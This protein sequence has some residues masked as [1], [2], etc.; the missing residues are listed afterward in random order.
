MGSNNYVTPPASTNAQGTVAVSVAPAVTASPVALGANDPRVLPT[1]SAAAGNIKLPYDTNSAYVE[2]VASAT[3]YAVPQ[4]NAGATGVAFGPVT[5]VNLDSSVIVAAG[6]NP[7]TGDQSHGWHNITSVGAI[8]ATTVNATNISA[9]GITGTTVAAD[10]VQAKTTDGNLT[11]Q[12]NGAG[13]AVAVASGKTLR[14]GSNAGAPSGIAVG[15]FY[16]DSTAK[17]PAMKTDVG[18]VD[19]P[20]TVYANTG[21]S[22]TINGVTLTEF[23]LTTTISAGGLNVQGRSL[24]VHADGIYSTGGTGG[25]VTLALRFGSTDYLTTAAITLPNNASNRAWSCDFYVNIRTTGATGNMIISG[26]A[27]YSNATGTVATDLACT[28][29]VS[30]AI[31]LTAA[32]T[33]GIAN[34]FSQANSSATM[35]NMVVRVLA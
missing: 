2:T 32:Q 12:P 3:P 10:T 29:G 18:T 19:I 5:S 23:S 20:Q 35:Q 16:Y 21:S 1:P 11:L 31:D 7:F 22:T 34:K 15:D 13:T 9:T 4:I 14:L 24:H 26:Q 17:S 25:N 8:G 30:A 6:T 27:N 28:N 33:V